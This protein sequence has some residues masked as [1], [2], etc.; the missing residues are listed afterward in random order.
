MTSDANEADSGGSLLTRPGGVTYMQI[1]TTDARKSAAFYTAVFGWTARQLDTHP[2]FDDASGYLS[3]A[4]STDRAISRV[5]GILPYIYVDR[6]DET[7]AKVRE[8]GG[9]VVREP[10]P[11]GGLWVATVRDP[12]GNV[13][14]V[15]HMGER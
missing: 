2:S 13:V 7:I 9:E 6:I 12:S 14:G 15:W 11:E 8:H 4:W 5:P 10:Y 3:G 1:P